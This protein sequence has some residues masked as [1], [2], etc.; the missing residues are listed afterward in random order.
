MQRYALLDEASCS[1]NVTLNNVTNIS[2]TCTPSI[3]LTFQVRGSW[4]GGSDSGVRH[5]HR[6]G[7]RRVLQGRR[8][9]RQLLRQALLSLAKG[10][11]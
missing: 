5:R 8:T 1:Q 11:N 3:I 10:D 6:P 2:L 7:G 4:R 9:R